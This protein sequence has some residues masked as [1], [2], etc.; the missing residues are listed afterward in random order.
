[1]TVPFVDLKRDSAQHRA[2]YL[3]ATA[4]VIDSGVF[5]LGPEVEAFER[6]FAA[7][8][9][10][11]HVVAVNG[12]TMA[13]YAS[14][15]ALGIGAGDEVIIPANT[16]IAT[17]EACV[18]VGATPRFC[19]IDPDSFLLDLTHAQTLM[20]ART[21]AI[22]P[23]HLY[24]RVVPMP[25]LLTWAAAHR[26]MVIEDAAQAHGARIAG[27]CAGSFGTVGCFSFYPTKNLGALGEGGAVAVQDV[28]LAARLRAVRLHG[29]SKDRYHH[30]VFGTN[31]KMDALQG[32]FLSLKLSWLDA[33]NMRRRVIAA[34][35]RAAFH[36]LPIDVPSDVGEAHVYHLFVIATDQRDALQAHLTERG[37]GTVIHY[38][39]PVYLQPSFQSYGGKIGDCPVAERFSSRILSLPLFPELRDEEVQE[40]IHAVKMFFTG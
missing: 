33:A 4:R 31:L 2:E 21:K 24:G 20:N 5:S 16:F 30:E 36:D 3:S 19:D 40:V 32:A 8:L 1:M 38:P 29:I 7:Y 26:L 12:G 28:D 27:R 9:D 10:V 14:L 37:I 35:Y 25:A 6:A 11:P 39:R 23:V 17:A 22:I 18:M 34:Q 15:L 13:L